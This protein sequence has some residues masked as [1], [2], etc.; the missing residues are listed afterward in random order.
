MKKPV[1]LTIV[2]YYCGDAAAP[3]VSASF[4]ALRP[5]YLA[6]TL[7]DAARFS[8]RTVVGVC[9]AHD[10]DTVVGL[11]GERNCIYAD[12]LAVPWDLPLE[13][14]TVLQASMRSGTSDLWGP[15]CGRTPKIVYYTEA[16]QVTNVTYNHVEFVLG[17]PA[18][19]H[20]YLA[21]HRMDE[22]YVGPSGELH[23]MSP[24]GCV[25]ALGRMWSLPNEPW[26]LREGAQGDPSCDPRYYKPT[27]FFAGYSAS[28]LCSTDTFANTR[29]GVILPGPSPE[30]LSVEAPSLSLYAGGGCY[31]STALEARGMD[32]GSEHDGIDPEAFVTVHLGGYEHCMRKAYPGR[33]ARLLEDDPASFCR[34]VVWARPAADLKQLWVPSAGGS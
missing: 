12:G 25:R 10:R 13:L 16:D 30:G 21:G 4:K 8:E 14:C 6:E 26:P 3:G 27:N 15:A 11:V 17:R 2:V 29:F 20:A 9:T 7:R 23:G 18:E 28:F 24:H 31:K 22:L 33:A 5:L 32:G 1:D 34:R 19:E